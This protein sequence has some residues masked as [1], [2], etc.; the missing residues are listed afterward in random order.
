M[1]KQLKKLVLKKET[2]A[3]LGLLSKDLVLARGGSEVET[4]DCTVLDLKKKLTITY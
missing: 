2:V 4:E 3:N 1:K